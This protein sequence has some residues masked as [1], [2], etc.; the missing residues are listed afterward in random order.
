MFVKDDFSTQAPRKNQVTMA[1]RRTSGNTIMGV[2]LISCRHCVCNSSRF[3]QSSW[4]HSHSYPRGKIRRWPLLLTSE[5]KIT[6]NWNN[7][8]EGN[9]NTGWRKVLH[10]FQSSTQAYRCEK[11]VVLNQ[12]VSSACVWLTIDKPSPHIAWSVLLHR[13][14]QEHMLWVLRL[15]KWRGILRIWWLIDVFEIIWKFTG[16]YLTI[17]ANW[18][19][20]E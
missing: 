18:L 2:C 14:N 9:N 6:S 7:T 3:V 5:N 10:I 4:T 1:P 19:F 11:A 13:L 15:A 16:I 20:P 17:A 12:F 8:G